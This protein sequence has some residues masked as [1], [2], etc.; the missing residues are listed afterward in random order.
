MKTTITAFLVLFTL[1]AFAQP[2][3][4]IQGSGIITKETREVGSYTAITSAGSWDVKIT[5]GTS[6]AIELEGDDNLLSYLETDLE[7]NTL[8]IKSKKYYNLNS[9]RKIIVHVYLTR[10]T[11]ISLAGSGDVIGTGN[12][13]NDGKTNFELAGSGN[14]NL[15]FQ[16][17]EKV[18]ISIAGSGNVNL[19]GKANEV[20]ISIA[21]S[22]D[23]NAERV[24]ADDVKV[25]IAGSGLAKVTANISLK[26]SIAGSGDVYYK[27]TA[28]NIK[29]SVIGSGKVR[30][31]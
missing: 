7:G 14:V 6:K 22:G 8:I 23:A 30:Q 25:S 20:A 21:G 16:T 31:L 27:G 26:A 9:R 11:G 29:K 28:T 24:I 1:T 10:L 4:K 19:A 13:T 12:F 15:D 3:K 5:Y 17:I 18:G 2:W